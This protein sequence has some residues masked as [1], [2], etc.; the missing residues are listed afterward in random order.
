VV[1]RTGWANPLADR[2]KAVQADSDAGFVVFVVTS[3]RGSQWPYWKASE[4][5]RTSCYWTRM[6]RFFKVFKVLKVF[7][8]FEA[9]KVC[10]IIS[11]VIA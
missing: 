10:S 5:K 3:A 9:F 6:S 1:Y 7:K 8:V 11:L 2:H 4:R